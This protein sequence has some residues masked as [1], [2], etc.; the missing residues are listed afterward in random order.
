MRYRLGILGGLAV[1]GI[2]AL[3]LAT[4]ISGSGTVE[5]ARPAVT[6]TKHEL[7]VAGA[8]IEGECSFVLNIGW[9]GSAYAHKNGLARIFLYDQAGVLIIYADTPIAKTPNG[10]SFEFDWGQRETGEYI[11]TVLLYTSRG[12]GGQTLGKMLDRSEVPLTC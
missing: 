11:S 9:E 6:V 2:L 7:M 4:G 5:A 3:G 1:M 12:K 8:A 10:G